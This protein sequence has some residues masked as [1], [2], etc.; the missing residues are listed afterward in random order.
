VTSLVEFAVL[1]DFGAID[2]VCYHFGGPLDDAPIEE[3]GNHNCLVK[4]IELYC[5]FVFWLF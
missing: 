1:K 5:C 3:L 2:A 4:K